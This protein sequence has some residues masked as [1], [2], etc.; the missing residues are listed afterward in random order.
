MRELTAQ[1]DDSRRI[2]DRCASHHRSLRRP[3]T[4]HVTTPDASKP[5][6]SAVAVPRS[7]REFVGIRK[8]LQTRCEALA[9][10]P[11]SSG[12]AVCREGCRDAAMDRRQERRTLPQL[13]FS[14]GLQHRSLP[15]QERFR[16][17][18]GATVALNGGNAQVHSVCPST[19][20]WRRQRDKGLWDHQ[21]ARL[22]SQLSAQGHGL[23]TEGEHDASCGAGP[24][25]AADANRSDSSR[26]CSLRVR[27]WPSSIGPEEWEPEWQV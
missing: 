19:W 1:T 11:R 4:S 20:L 23:R 17:A 10:D 12:A 21:A 22:C 2:L 27:V 5:G 14:L 8:V 26:W 15:S 7:L 24:W 16:R 9:L 6:H 25:L 18:G 3:T 13:S